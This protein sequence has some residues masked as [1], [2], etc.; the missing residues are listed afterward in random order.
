M[1]AGILAVR[2]H[3]FFG[4]CNLVVVAGILVG[5]GN[6]VV[7]GILVLV[8]GNPVVEGSLVAVVGSLLAAE[9]SIHILVVGWHL[10]FLSF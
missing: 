1:V 5:V 7:V 3:C 9:G 10:E 8:V 4:C 6:P 2:I